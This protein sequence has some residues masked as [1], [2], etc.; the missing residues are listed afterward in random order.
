[1]YRIHVPVVGYGG[2]LLCC[3]SHSFGL[4]SLLGCQGSAQCVSAIALGEV[5]IEA[6]CDLL[7][8]KSFPVENQKEINKDEMMT[9]KL[10][11]VPVSMLCCTG[12][13]KSARVTD[14]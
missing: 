1:M 10:L 13:A 9:W 12:S 11:H 6:N 5:R 2:G 7:R 8:A 4:C 3:S 14:V